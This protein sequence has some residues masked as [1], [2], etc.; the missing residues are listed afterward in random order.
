MYYLERAAYAHLI[1]GK[2]LLPWKPDSTYRHHYRRLLQISLA[3]LALGTRKR[4]RDGALAAQ[5]QEVIDRSQVFAERSVGA[6]H[7]HVNPAGII[8]KRE[9]CRCISRWRRYFLIRFLSDLPW[10]MS[11]YR[12]YPLRSLSRSD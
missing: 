9:A 8:S 11:N 3:H 2:D 12:L 4:W 6:N 10:L 1:A 5:G 7:L